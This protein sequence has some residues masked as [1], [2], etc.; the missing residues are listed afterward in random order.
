MLG[1]DKLLK[2]FA[3]ILLERSVLFTAKHLRYSHCNGTVITINVDL[4]IIQF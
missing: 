1:A 4:I 3:S 2:V